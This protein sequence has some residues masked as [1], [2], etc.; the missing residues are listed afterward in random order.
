ML[1]PL[2]VR[3]SPTD[4]AAAERFIAD[5]LRRQG[6]LY[7]PVRA[8]GVAI[9]LLGVLGFVGLFRV[10]L[11]LEPEIQA[12]IR[13]SALMLLGAAALAVLASF[14]HKRS[15]A[16]VLFRPDGKLLKP[17]EVTAGQSGLALTTS[18]GRAEVP[19]AAVERAQI[20]G[21]YLY[22]FTLPHYAIVI[23]AASF[24]SNSEFAEF[25]QAITANLPSNAA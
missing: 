2:T 8:I 23:P 20:H 4:Y 25:A 9:G 18:T 5:S 21:R 3:L 7:W 19:W 22:I 16:S 12:Q 6:P 11:P 24:A 10:E 15:I 14:L 17:F 1:A 13:A